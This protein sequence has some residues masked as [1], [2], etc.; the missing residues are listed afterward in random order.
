M[1]KMNR[2]A[3]NKN[4]LITAYRPTLSFGSIEKYRVLYV[5]ALI[6]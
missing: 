2:N 5:T 4:K 1:N 6:K 3:I